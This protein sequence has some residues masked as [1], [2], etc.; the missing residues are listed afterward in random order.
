MKSVLLMKV[1]DKV[2]RT[3]AEQVTPGSSHSLSLE[4]LG[5]GNYVMLW[6]LPYL[7]TFFCQIVKLFFS[8]YVH[9]YL[10]LL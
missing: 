8:K 5:M 4:N 2:G 1:V 6:Q 7:N 9:M 3:L 10:C